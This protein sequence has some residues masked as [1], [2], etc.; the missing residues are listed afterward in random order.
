MLVLPYL[1]GN[2]MTPS[3]R[4]KT[5]FLVAL[6]C[7]CAMALPFAHAHAQSLVRDAEAEHIIR[8]YA[9][10]IFKA[11]GLIPKN[12]DIYLINDRNINA[13]V[14]G[15]QKMFIHTGLITEL[16]SPEEIIGIIAHETGHIAGGHLSRA[17]EAMASATVP[18]ILSTI[19]GAAAMIA[20]QGDAGVGV[21]AAG[22]QI[23][24]RS[25][26]S[27]SRVQEASADQA[28]VT[29][30]DQTGQ[31]G[32]GILK[33]FKDFSTQEALSSR[34]QDPY[35]R[36]HPMSSDRIASLAEKV[37]KSPYYNKELDNETVR[38]FELL[39]AKVRG[40]L[41]E[42]TTTLR[43]YPSKRTDQPAR[44]ARAV[45]YHRIPNM[46][47]ALAEIDGLLKE[48]SENPYFNELKGQILFESGKVKEAVPWH[49]RSV[50]LAPNEP[51]LLINLAQA[52][53]ATE[54]PALL[55]IAQQNLEQSIRLDE[56]NSM[57]FYQL[58]IAHDRKGEPGLAALAT[59]E[60]MYRSG[61]Y[62]EARIQ[63]DR[64]Q[65][66]LKVGSPQ[67]LRAEDIKREAERQRARMRS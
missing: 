21:I 29:Y 43:M 46:P 7:L 50:D 14:T 2:A 57:A 9:E 44:Y 65:R 67:W 41:F 49:Q 33:V 16:K 12:V 32:R 38:Q 59:A 27:Y 18:I 22:Q 31:S 39:Q 11:A 56:E 25:F 10:P 66:S 53:L 26:L 13:F 28:A 20:G 23:A 64:A 3:S 51:L 30:L 48:D 24:E 47:K 6:G 4:I 34:H 60:R 54:D 63:A 17:Q 42:P 62:G 58:A 37:T 55:N 19:L 1:N 35:A 61:N 8:G 52:Q 36:S 45:A 15:G 40:F 5:L